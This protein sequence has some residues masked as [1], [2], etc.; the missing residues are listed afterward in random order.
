M[1]CLLPE[2]LDIS[3]VLDVTTLYQKWLTNQDPIELNAEKVVRV[4]AAGIQLLCCLFISAKKNHREIHLLK[5][6]EPLTDGIQTLG[7]S[8]VFER[9]TKVGE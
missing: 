9:T 8:G 5:P 2:S 4:D 1:N 3:T 6:T 7:F